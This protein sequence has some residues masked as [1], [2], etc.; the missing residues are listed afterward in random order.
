MTKFRDIILREMTGK[1]M[2]SD[3][4]QFQDAYRYTNPTI[5]DLWN[6]VAMPPQIIV[7]EYLL[8]FL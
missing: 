8:D 6:D 4:G 1:D 2:E 5:Y 3:L 7:L